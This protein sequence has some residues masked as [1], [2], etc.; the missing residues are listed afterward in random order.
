[1][2]DTSMLRQVLLPAAVFIFSGMAWY[3][4]RNLEPT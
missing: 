1:M 3:V 4:I 2:N